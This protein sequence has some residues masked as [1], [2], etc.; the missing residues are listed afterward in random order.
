ME[1][2]FIKVTSS[3]NL[4]RIVNLSHVVQIVQRGADHCQV[5][6]TDGKALELDASETEQLLY[7]TGIKKRQVRAGAI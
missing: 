7:G 5:I 2:K 3:Q 4:W 6:L 1:N